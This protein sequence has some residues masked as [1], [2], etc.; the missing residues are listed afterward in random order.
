[1]SR[2]RSHASGL[3]ALDR[4]PLATR[5]LAFE[6]YLKQ[7]LEA[8][9]RAPGRLGAAIR[10][11]ALGAG[12]RVRPLLALTACEA[13]SGAWRPALPAAAALECVHAFSLA[14]DDLPAMDD[15][16]YRR[17]RLTT[18]RK[19]GEALGILA[20]DALLAF[21]FEELTRLERAGL[22]AARV[23]EASRRLAHAAG[24]E[25]LVA[26]QALDVAAEGRRATRAEV[27]SIHARKTGALL[28]AALALGALVGGADAARVRAF[29]RAGRQLGL[30]FQIQDDLLNAG[31]SLARLGKRAG[32]DAARGKATYPGAVGRE[33]A[34]HRRAALMAAAATAVRAAARHPARLLETIGALEHRER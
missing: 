24:G 17:G 10:Y 18:H 11:A 30:A 21:A 13:V 15:D 32:T 16:D 19:F 22:N 29:D 34:E 33:R 9:C 20:G 5:R 23:I 6:R 28:G 7:A 25:E 14:H 1:M 4:G 31:S 12:K 2:L 8:R 27:E 26:G 3:G